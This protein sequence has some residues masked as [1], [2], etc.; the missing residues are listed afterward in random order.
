MFI[1]G[2]C[3]GAASW[4]T[5]VG[6][7]SFGSSSWVVSFDGEKPLVSWLEGEGLVFFLWSGRSLGRAG[8]AQM[9][10]HSALLAGLGQSLALILSEHGLPLFCWVMVDTGVSVIVWDLF[11]LLLIF[12][13]GYFPIGF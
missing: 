5:S 4:E 11:L 1:G 7:S 6:I 9:L 8:R 2:W 3:G 12:T 10:S 13:R